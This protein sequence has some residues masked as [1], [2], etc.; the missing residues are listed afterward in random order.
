MKK[1]KRSYSQLSSFEECQL[2]YYYNKIEKLESKDNIWSAVGLLG[3]DTFEK[4]EKGEIKNPY[5]YF[6][7][8]YPHNLPVSDFQQKQK[9]KLH[10]AVSKYFQTFSGWRTKAIGLEE[11]FELDF[12]EFIFRGIIDRYS[13]EGKDYHIQDYKVSNPYIGE[14]LESKLKQLYLYSA[15]IKDKYGKYPKKLT[16]LFFKTGDYYTEQFSLTK[17]NR[18]VDWA[19]RINEEILKATKD[20]KFKENKDYFFCTNICSFKENCKAWKQ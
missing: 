4:F 16:F 2:S 3:H 11:S 14:G 7:E 6:I 10:K 15:H 8:N 17:F 5:K 9:E 18:A 13:L 20:K 19:K 12:K 1:P